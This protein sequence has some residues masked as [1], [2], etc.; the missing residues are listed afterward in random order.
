MVNKKLESFNNGLREV[1]YN[2]ENATRYNERLREQMFGSM[3]E[4]L[5]KEIKR[6]I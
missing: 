3:V 2:L 4:E 6:L 1:N 5:R